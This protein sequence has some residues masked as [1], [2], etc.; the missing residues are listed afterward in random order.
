[1]TSCYTFFSDREDSETKE[2]DLEDHVVEHRNISQEEGKQD[3]DEEEVNQ[4]PHNGGCMKRTREEDEED[5]E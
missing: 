1:M 4:N 3:G 2:S 5:E